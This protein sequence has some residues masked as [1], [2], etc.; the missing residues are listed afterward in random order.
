MELNDEVK[1]ALT[2]WRDL[3]KRDT[4]SREGSS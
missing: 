3:T 1:D 4:S 2:L